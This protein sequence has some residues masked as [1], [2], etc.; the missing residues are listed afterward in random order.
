M[1]CGNCGAQNDDSNEYCINCGANLKQYMVGGPAP[2]AAPQHAARGMRTPAPAQPKP[3]AA[4]AAYPA[5]PQPVQPAAARPAPRPAY[6][7]A[8]ARPAAATVQR[9]AA[10]VPARPVGS[11]AAPAPAQAAPAGPSSAELPRIVSERPQSASMPSLTLVRANGTR[12][13][14]SEFPATVGKGSAAN[15]RIGG[16]TAISRVHAII[17]YLG[18]GF[19]VEDRASTNGTFINGNALFAGERV[20][21]HEGDRLTLGDEDFIV[22]IK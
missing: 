20:A 6:P 12:Y 19:S 13:R 5:A 11:H 4:S 18:T 9:P 3:K 1:F 2:A 10:A 21:L 7:G 17:K 8:A 16:N 14:I 22:E 15:V